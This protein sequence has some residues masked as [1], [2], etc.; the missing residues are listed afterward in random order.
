M[1]KIGVIGWGGRGGHVANTAHHATGGLIVPV[2]CVEPFDE[3]YDRGCRDWG[4]TPNRYES[5]EQMLHAETLD[6]A[7]IASPNF[8]H[9]EHLRPFAPAEIPLL[10]EKPLDSTFE[11]ICDVL[12]FAR[13]YKASILVG[14][15]M[16][17]AP[18]LNEA[19]KILDRGQIG[20]ICSVRFVQNCHYGNGG[21][22]GWR[23]RKETSGTWLIEKATHDFDVMFW[24][25]AATPRSV[26]AVQKLQAFGGDKPDDL[27]CRDCPERVTCPESVQNIA[28]RNGQV[29]E[30]KNTDDLCAFAGEVDTPDNDVCLFQ[31][32][33]GVFGTYAQWFF[34]PRSYR[35]RIYEIHGTE[36]AM[37][38]DMGAEHGGRILLCPRFGTPD[39]AMEYKFDYLGR[40]HYNGDGPMTQHFYHVIRGQAQPHATVEQAFVAELMGYAAIRAAENQQWVSLREL[41][42]DDVADV[43]D[44]AVY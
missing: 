32:D 34:S 30:L 38:I 31:L 26:T 18:I 13:R 29:E 3:A 43:Q 2:A 16:R 5:V 1:A 27:R 9:L 11:K 28:Y 10:L 37:E 36:G 15:C 14:H 41:L 19:K 12:R 20:R 35:H 39:D 8:C 17:F 7:I 33:N 4:F 42:P 22:H 25:I 6:G 21:Y 23:R 24:L 44:A 40:N